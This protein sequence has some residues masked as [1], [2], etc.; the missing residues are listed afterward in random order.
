VAG[1]KSFEHVQCEVVRAEIERNAD[2]AIGELLRGIDRG[3]RGHHESSEGHDGAAAELAAA[4]GR[5]L[6]SQAL[7]MSALPCSS[8]RPWL[9]KGSSPFGLSTSVWASRLPPSLVLTH[10]MVSPSRANRPSASAT[11][12]GNPWNGAVCSMTSVFMCSSC[13]T[14]RVGTSL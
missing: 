13:S 14:S 12:S 11:S 3:V 9:R 2:L 7:Y 6:H 4:N 8:S 5:V 10:W 1:Q